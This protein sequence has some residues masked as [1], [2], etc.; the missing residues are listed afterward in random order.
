[1]KDQKQFL[2]QIFQKEIAWRA[3]QDTIWF[4]MKGN[5]IRF[6]RQPHLQN[7]KTELKLELMCVRSGSG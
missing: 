6:G 2:R 7:V 1:M 3:A 4:N 5:I